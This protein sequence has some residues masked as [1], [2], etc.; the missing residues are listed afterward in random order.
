M[1]DH[2]TIRAMIEYGGSFASNIGKAAMAADEE[3]YIKLRN[4]F[5][6]LFNDYKQRFVKS[7]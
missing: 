5:A 1:K 2:D 3:N 4:A 7:K 6:D